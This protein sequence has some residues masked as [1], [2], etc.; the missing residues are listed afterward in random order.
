MQ[1]IKVI[2]TEPKRIVTSTGKPD[3]HQ[4]DNKSKHDN[5]PLSEVS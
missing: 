5:K 4:R 2:K 1:K 3:Q